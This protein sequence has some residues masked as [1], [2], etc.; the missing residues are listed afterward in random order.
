MRKYLKREILKI[1]KSLEDTNDKIY[2]ANGNNLTFNNESIWEECQQSA[3]EIGNLIDHIEGEDTKTVHLLEEYCEY[4]YMLSLCQGDVIKTK[5]ILKKVRHL[6][7]R[8]TNSIW[9]DLPESKKEI[10]FLPYKASMWDSMESVWSAAYEDNSC[11]V[12]V[13]PIP[14]FDRNNDGSVGEMHDE[15]DKYP[16]N[17][18][19]TSWKEY[20][21][22]QNH[23]DIVFIHNPYDDRNLITSVHPSF[24]SNELKR[25]T[26]ML[27]YIPYFVGINDQVDE[28][29][30]VLPAIVHADKV[31]VQSEKVRQI[32]INQYCKFEK[33]NN[34]EDAFGK[35]KEKFIAL[36]SPKYDKVL[37]AKKGDIYIPD[38]WQKCIDNKGKSKKS[39]ILYNTTISGMLSYNHKM[40][41]K[42]KRVFSEFQKRNDVVL[43]WRPHPLL[44][45]TL[46]SML[47]DLYYDYCCLEEQYKA[48]GWGIYDDTADMYRAIVLSDAYYGDWSSVVELYRKTGKPVMIQNIDVIKEIAD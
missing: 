11:E 16:K 38:E 31:I 47:P 45:T 46:Q 3:I 36:G 26:D 20:S 9:Y 40:I 28:H 2:K 6:L 5:Q 35:A 41:S 8:I 39:I 13:V 14:Y 17:I 23:P 48:A 37:S 32:Y 42:I 29:F 24:Y 22:E 1:V 7:T 34:C 25:N 30:C 18:P 4:V 43:L 27:V 21:I 15:S 10:V 44:K 33:E 12:Y 19:I